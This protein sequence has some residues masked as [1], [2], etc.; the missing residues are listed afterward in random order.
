MKRILFAL[1]AL[2]GAA[3]CSDAS[4]PDRVACAPE[5]LSNTAATGDTI[6]ANGLRYVEIREGSGPVAGNGSAVR[7]HYTGY[8]LNGTRFDTSC[9][10]EE[11]LRFTI[12]TSSLIPG[13]YLGTAG[14]R[15]GGVRRVIV[16]PELAYGS[17][18]QGSIPPNATLVFDLE[19]S[20]VL[21]P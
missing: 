14:M 12:P 16:P 5:L 8:L 1:A 20:K 3:A 18:G 13:F 2:A 4:G 17:R 9:S 15:E 19:L 10:T 11:P 21:N 6:T 7:V